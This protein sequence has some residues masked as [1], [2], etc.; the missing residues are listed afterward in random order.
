MSTAGSGERPGT[1]LATPTYTRFAGTCAIGAAIVGLAYSIAFV[2]I[3]DPLLYSLLLMIGAVL[4]SVAVIAFADRLRAV[5][6]GFA[7]WGMVLALAGTL[8]AGVHGAYDLANAINPPNILADGG[9]S[10]LPS[11]ID[12]RGFLTFAVA[13]L[14]LLVLSWLVRR[15]RSF[16]DGLGWL[17]LGLGALL[18]VIYLGRLIVLDAASPLVLGPAALAGLIVNPA[19]YLWLGRELLREGSTG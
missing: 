17:G 9:M 5:D 10:E 13:G 15:D 19:F 3:K 12:P 14:G 18:I 8:G 7:T 11:A 16:P 6:A 2:V 1:P 4:T